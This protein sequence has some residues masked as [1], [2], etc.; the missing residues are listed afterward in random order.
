M[1][2]TPHCVTHKLKH[3]NEKTQRGARKG[4]GGA[5]VDAGNAL[6]PARS[7][8]DASS[9]KE[10]AMKEEREDGR[11]SEE[12]GAGGGKTLRQTKKQRY[13]QGLQEKRV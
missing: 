5:K 9:S 4:T 11:K 1:R 7:M 8:T 12:G 2:G 10:R 13:S 6:A 3:R